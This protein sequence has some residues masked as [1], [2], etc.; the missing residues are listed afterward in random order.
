MNMRVNYTGD[1][2][3]RH[4]DLLPRF[5]MHFLDQFNTSY[6][7]NPL[8]HNKSHS[9]IN[10]GLAVY[11]EK[12]WRVF[13][14]T[15]L[16]VRCSRGFVFLVLEYC[17]AVWCSSADTHHKLQD[18]V[19]NGARFLTGGVFECDIV[20][21]WS[22][23]SIMYAMCA[24]MYDQVQPYAPSLWCSTWTVCVSAG[25]AQCFGRTSG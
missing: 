19:V 10:K 6:V 18:R 23:D 12:S 8:I 2:C 13:H 17:S 14:D 24:I 22:V 15:S 20:H 1:C 21:R 11:F 9:F 16:L 4:I 7:L 3:K 25:Y 5:H